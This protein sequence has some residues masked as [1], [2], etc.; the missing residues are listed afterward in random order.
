[1]PQESRDR[2]PL[3]ENGAAQSKGSPPSS[4][5]IKTA[6]WLI[7]GCLTWLSLVYLPKDVLSPE[8]MDPSIQGS[9]SYFAEKQIQF[10]PQIMFTYGPFGYL[11]PEVYDGM[12]FK[13][14]LLVELVSK[15][16]IVA[17]VLAIAR[18]LS[19]F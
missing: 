6:A 11:M 1:M 10:G 8:L 5:H 9:L 14:R 2:F 15:I 4:R 3:A 12:F 18:E 16:F 7:A 19:A 17:V 13:R